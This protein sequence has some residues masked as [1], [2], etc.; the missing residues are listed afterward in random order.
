MTR[1]IFWYLLTVILL[2]GCAFADQSPNADANYQQLR[3]ITLG[4]EAITVSNL[5]LKRDAATFQLNS[6]T[7][8]F[9]SPVG[10]KVTGAIF[11]GEGRLLLTP[12]IP[13]EGRSLTLL[14]KEAEFSESFSRLVLRFTDDTYKQL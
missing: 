14:T 2:V 10:S 7:L 5:T 4:T 3:T 13:A 6:G 1:A 11:V 8:C 12:P 9:L